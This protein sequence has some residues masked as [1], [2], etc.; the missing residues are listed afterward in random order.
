MNQEDILNLKDISLQLYFLHQKTDFVIIK[1][2]G[3][4]IVLFVELV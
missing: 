1:N 3:M 2:K 4:S